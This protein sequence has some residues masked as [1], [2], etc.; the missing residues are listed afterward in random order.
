MKP[1]NLLRFTACKVSSQRAERRGDEMKRELCAF[2]SRG[3]VFFN[4]NKE[5]QKNG[6]KIFYFRIRDGRTSR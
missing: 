5:R 3:K 1:D 6:K 4:K 2:P